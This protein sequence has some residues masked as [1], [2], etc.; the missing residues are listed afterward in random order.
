[1]QGNMVSDVESGAYHAGAYSYS[2]YSS[3]CRSNQLCIK[4]AMLNVITQQNCVLIMS[5][6]YNCE[7]ENKVCNLILYNS[8]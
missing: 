6:V 1:M 3:I 5:I 4:F 2:V 7:T 8:K